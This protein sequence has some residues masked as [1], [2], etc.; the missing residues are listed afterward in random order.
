[1]A[2]F[3]SSTKAKQAPTKLTAEIIDLDYQGLGVAKIA[4]KT[5]FVENA[6]PQ[7]IVQFSVLENKRQYGLGRTQKILQPSPQRQQPVCVYYHQCGGCQGQHIP[8]ELQRQA[9]QQALFH[10]LS[11]W[12][13]QIEFMPMI[14]GEPWHYRRRIRL[15]LKI[16][17]KTKQLDFGFRQKHSQ[18][19]IRIESCVVVE[20]ELNKIIQKLTALLP[21]WKKKQALGHIELVK[22]DNG[23][24]ML[25][26]HMGQLESQDQALLQ[27]FA[28]QQAVNL[29]VQTDDEVECY[30]GE[31][32]FYHLANM[33]LQFDIRDF[34][35]INSEVNQQMVQTALD[36]LQLSSQDQVLDLFCGM[37]NFSLPLSRW[38][39]N[40][41]GIEGVQ[42]MVD[43]ATNNAQQNACNNVKFYQADLTQPFEHQ[44]WAKQHFNKILLDPPRA[45]AD[46]ILNNICKLQADM[47]LYISCNPA[48]LV[49]DA[50]I[51]LDKGYQLRKLAM[52][53][54]FPHTGHLESISLFERQ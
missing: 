47:I 19:I 2:L 3:Y 6:L 44:I 35:Q 43:K 16:N 25:L 32:P 29:F 51:L 52:I 5:W 30:Y 12:H 53:D 36:W 42:A 17:P 33:K 15:S 50:K 18:Q 54:M 37:G 28:Q 46:F 8:I 45:G 20:P 1:M 38:V 4:G 10:Q 26:R 21:Q 49:R 27:D 13:Q 24:C 39:N 22:A 34:I 9:K 23:V 7:E 48:T 41:V 11:Q 31:M 14:S 40:V